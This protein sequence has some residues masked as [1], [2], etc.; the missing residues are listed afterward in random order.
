M[1]A[2]TA[3][4]GR[5][6]NYGSILQFS[7]TNNPTPGT[8]SHWLTQLWSSTVEMLG[9]RWR[10][11]TGGWTA[12]KT[13]AFTDS[14]VASATKLQTARTLWG[15]SFNGTANV[16]GNMTGVGS[17]NAS[18]N[19][20]TSSRMAA[21]GVGNAYNTLAFEAVGNGSNLYPGIGF[22][23]PGRYGASL[24]VINGNFWFRNQ[25]DND[26]VPI[27]A[28]TLNSY[29]PQGTAPLTVASTTQVANLN[30][31]YLQGY[32][33]SESSIANTIVRR[34]ANNYVWLKYI[35][36]DTTNNERDS[37]NQFIITNGNDGFYR[38]VSIDRVRTAL[39][40]RNN[41]IDLRSLDPNTWYPCSI[42]VDPDEYAEIAIWVS[43]DDNKPTW[44]TH[45]SGFTLN[46]RWQVTGNGWGTTLNQRKILN[47]HYGFTSVN[48]C[49]GIT[50]NTMASTE[51]VY[52]RGGGYYYYYV[53]TG[54][55]I[56]AHTGG[57][58]WVNGEYSYSAPTRTSVLNDPRDQ[59]DNSFLGVSD[60]WSTSVRTSD[61]LASKN[62]R[63]ECD[64][65][66]NSIGRSSEI[67]NYNSHLYLQHNSGTS[68]L[69]CNGGGNMGVGTTNATAKLTVN[70][71]FSV[72]STSTFGNSTYLNSGE[73]GFSHNQTYYG[74]GSIEL[75]AHT[76]FIDFHHDNST[77]D[78]TSRIVTR[79]IGELG[80]TGSVTID[81]TLSVR[82]T[83]SFGG[84]LTANGGIGLGTNHGVY[85]TAAANSTANI[86]FIMAD[87]DYARI[88]VGGSSNNGFLEIATADDGTEPIYVS[89]YS[90][91][92]SSIVRTLTL[93]DGNGNTS[94]PN[95]L[96][97]GG[98]IRTN[99][100]IS[101]GEFADDVYG[102]IN[103]TRSNN[104]NNASCFSW[105][106]SSTTAFG[107]GFD[108]T[109]R[110]VLGSANSN[111][112]INPYI[113]IGY[114]HTYVSGTFYAPTGIWSDGYVS[115]KGQNTASDMRLKT[116]ERN[117]VL[118]ASDIANAPSFE[119][120]WKTG[121]TNLE[122][123]SSAQYWQTVLPQAVKEGHDK[124][125][126]MQYGN[127]ALVSVISL[128]KEVIALQKEIKELRQAL[129]RQA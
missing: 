74:A 76:P 80:I 115:A 90:G 39:N 27:H 121:T 75:Y 70:G 51:I 22:H 117:V 41:T 63:I 123:G 55:S 43:L 35:H 2:D 62:I 50:Q 84:Y 94:I 105:I 1:Y 15:Q 97:A 29:A 112:T 37:V 87:N 108:T 116:V 46:L 59:R 79:G 68:L 129:S 33:Q 77:S 102:Y 103:V 65:N 4:S 124:Y 85:L 114:D 71:T 126:T 113:T 8:V 110:I 83:S 67:N 10:T 104:V 69:V 127:I 34:D 19:I 91:A 7:N 16:S 125:L 12:I 82:S 56:V 47:S 72:S 26:F 49:G 98:Y 60:I 88:L 25:S 111:K 78:Y 100:Y 128:A 81:N 52:L 93:L 57:Y 38:K 40:T 14:N 3:T 89:Q 64:N 54:A 73:Y 53:S 28:Y 101:A 45:G 61:C 20:S 109:S 122:V 30:A 36:S 5:W 86:H 17:I 13:I 106:R 58:S 42:H 66:Y 120:R 96:T 21:V 99:S 11:S 18:G 95:A 118:K 9:V 92:F 44:A 24:Y 48:P 23:Q 6:T 119:Y 107:L 31:S 32:T